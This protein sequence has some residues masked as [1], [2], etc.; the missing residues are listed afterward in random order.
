MAND[1]N[2]LSLFKILILNSPGLF[3]DGHGILEAGS[4]EG[5]EDLVDSH[6]VEV[7]LGR[8][9]VQSL[10]GSLLVSAEEERTG[11]CCDLPIEEAGVE[12]P[13]RESNGR[14]VVSENIKESMYICISL[15]YYFPI[16]LYCF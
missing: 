11:T 15:N 9:E 3:D 12:R 7:A 14:N 2:H 4:L 5:Y 8:V 1:I 10:P 6:E 13:G 16:F